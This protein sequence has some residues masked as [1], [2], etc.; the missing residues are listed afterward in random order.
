MSFIS[1]VPFS[2]KFLF[3]KNLALMIKT[4]LPLRESIATIQEQSKNRS[5]KK[6]LGDVIKNIENGQSLTVSLS[7]HPQI[8]DNLYIS[9][10]KVGEESGTLEEN[11]NHLILELEKSY[12]LRSKVK[13]ATVYPSF[14]LIAVVALTVGLTFLVLPQIVPIFETFD[15]ELPLATKILVKFIETTQTYGLHILVGIVVFLI[16]SFL[17]SKIRSVKYLFDKVILKIPI[18]GPIAKNVSLA[19]FSWTLGI[20]LQSGLPLVKA[21]EITQGVLKNL[22]FQKELMEISQEVQKGKSISDYLRNKESIFPLM[23]SRMIAV[24]EK[25][26][27]LEETLL[28]LG[29]FYEA[30]VDK[31][32]KNLSTILEP[33]LLLIIGA[34][35]ALV[36]LAIISPIYEITRGLHL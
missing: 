5:F 30:E 18:A 14:I 8:F 26:G 29:D 1:Q 12:E 7:N 13:A 28:Y 15:I 32:V 11:L 9:M 19:Q 35:V 6:A 27:S 20:L 16:F 36:A 22:V 24:G 31:T 23:I 21:L 34:V 33:A 25:T 4:G 10:I 2:E 3:T 17:I